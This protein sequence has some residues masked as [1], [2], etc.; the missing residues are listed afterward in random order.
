MSNELL[1]KTKIPV[2][3]YTL[4][5]TRHVLLLVIRYNLL[6]PLMQDS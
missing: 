2:T 6:N 4:P 3:R 5:I 1:V